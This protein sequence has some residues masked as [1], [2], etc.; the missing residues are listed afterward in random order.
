MRA[1]LYPLDKNW[2]WKEHTPTDTASRVAEIVERR[3][4]WNEALHFPSEIHVELKD[5]NII[6]DPYLGFNEHKVQC[7][8]DF[9][10]QTFH[11]SL[12][13]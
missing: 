10:S 6:P 5:A 3:S 11:N 8:S 4:G 7:E 13:T 1:T 9:L 12:T 2:E